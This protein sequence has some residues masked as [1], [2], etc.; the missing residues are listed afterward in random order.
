MRAGRSARP[1]APRSTRAARPGE[2][3][4]GDAVRGIA[5]VCVLL[6]HLAGGAL[7]LTNLYTPN[8]FASYGRISGAAM[9]ELELAVPMFFVLS[10]YLI[11][12][13][14][15]RAYVLGKPAPS[16]RRYVRNRVVRIVP[17]F[18]VLGAVMLALYGTYGSSPFDLFTIFSFAQIYHKSGAQLVLLGPAWSVDV[19]V[20][21]YVIVPVAA[22]AF[23][24]ATRRVGIHLGRDLGR[25]GRVALILSLVAV[26]AVASAW[27]QS[28]KYGT[29]WTFSPFATFYSFAPGIALAAL[30]IEVTGVLGRRRPRLLAPALALCAAVLAVA[31]AIAT[32]SN[33][34][35]MIQTRGELAVALACGL[36]VAALLTR[37]VVRGDSPRWV[38]NRAT[39]WLGEASYP[40]YLVQGATFASG[41]T[42]IGR[43]GG[44]PWIN[45]LV[46]GAFVLP[47]TVAVG[48][49][50]HVTFERPVNVWGRGRRPRVP[51]PAAEAPVE[52][53][54]LDQ[55]VLASVA[56]TPPEAR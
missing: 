41:V 30:E 25:R 47:V 2:F 13:P 55:P 48:S 33:H 14:W 4:A 54:R 1:A 42:I 27:L 12:R 44:G 50:V 32:V 52:T 6:L 37:Q 29:P 19:E 43:V 45:L 56:V 34:R 36:A 10:G 24:S 20:A 40:C 7:V 17:V 8:S 38:N 15:I 28:K 49:F 9:Y 35:A 5:M 22:F 51:V 46:M 39:R 31:M 16:L 18:W 3:L 11:S 23:A 26:A 53:G 21:F